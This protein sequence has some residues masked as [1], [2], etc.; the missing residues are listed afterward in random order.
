MNRRNRISTQAGFTLIELLLVVVIIGILAAIVVPNIIGGAD[1]ARL[2]SART[3]VKEFSNAMERYKMHCKTYP[4]TE[5]G[6]EALLVPSPSLNNP[7]NWKGPYMKAEIVPLDPW[8]YEFQYRYPSDR[9]NTWPDIF[10][11]GPDGQP[12]T[13]DDIY[14]HET[15]D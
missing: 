5:E 6:L 7:D 9:G 13:E 1:D 15:I 2:E 12:D 8:D 3:Q 10:S 11:V 4:S 14:P